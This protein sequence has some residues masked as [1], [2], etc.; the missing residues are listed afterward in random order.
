MSVKIIHITGAS[1]SGTTTIA[2]AI[3]E[4]FGYTHLDTDD[5]FWEDT[6]PPF[7]QKTS[8][9]ERRLKLGNAMKAAG[10]CVISGSLTEWGDVFIP[11]FDLVLYVST[12]TTVRL[13]R[14][15]Q[16]ELQSFGDRILPGGDMFDNHQKFIQWAAQYD[17][18]GPDMRSAGHH[19]KWLEQI[20][21]PVIFLDGAAP[22][23]ETLA[24]L[25]L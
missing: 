9:H 18:G 4:H 1:G 3:Q 7:T 6:D 20:P 23:H 15:R 11:Q 19:K 17:T 14:L 12:S 21:C 13:E 22:L 2:K 10:K 25:P 16:R 8:L 24:K 5:F